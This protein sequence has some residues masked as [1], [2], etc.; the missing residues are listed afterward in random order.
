MYVLIEEFLLD[1]NQR[2]IKVLTDNE[3]FYSIDYYEKID[4]EPE[5]IKKVSINNLELCYFN[6]NE[7]CKGLM[8]KSS[9]FIEIISLR[10]FMDKEEYNKISDKEIYTRCLELINNFKLNYKK[11]Q[12][13]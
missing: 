10:Y 12:N 4:F 7:R 8:V 5:C 6:I 3:A 13:P 2:G 1:G 9:D 11:E